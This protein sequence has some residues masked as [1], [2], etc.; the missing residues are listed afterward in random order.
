[1][2]IKYLSIFLISLLT[3]EHIAAENDASAADLNQAIANKAPFTRQKEERIALIKR[4]KAALAL[5]LEQYRVNRV[6]Y[7]EYQKFQ[8]DSAVSYALRNLNIAKM[9]GRVELTLRAQLDLADIYFP[10]NKFLEA[11]ELLQNV[12]SARFRRIC[13]RI[14]MP[15]RRNFI[16][17]TWPITRMMNIRVG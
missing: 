15:P 16:V 17:I 12:R 9:A 1:V 2:K 14:I 11:N 3:V 8:I 6:L 5:P 4:T 13:W 7:L 10:L